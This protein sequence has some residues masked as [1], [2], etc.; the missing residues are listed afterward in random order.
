[1][2]F[3]FFFTSIE[4]FLFFLLYLLINL[5]KKKSRDKNIQKFCIRISH[6]YRVQFIRIKVMKRKD[7]IHG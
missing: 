5:L 6:C 1:M 7:K 3:F 4:T 2:Y